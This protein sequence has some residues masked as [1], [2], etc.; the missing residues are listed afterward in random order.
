MHAPSALMNDGSA[1]ADAIQSHEK[2]GN[3]IENP[4]YNTQ[5]VSFLH[6][7]AEPVMQLQEVRD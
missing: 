5:P 1:V 2:S 6:A 7:G 4:V 3:F